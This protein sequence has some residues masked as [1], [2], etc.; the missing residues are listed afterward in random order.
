MFKVSLVDRLLEPG[1]NDIPL[2]I[3]TIGLGLFLREY[4]HEA[5]FATPQPFPSVFGN[6]VWRPGGVAITADDVGVIVVCTAVIAAR[7]SSS[8]AGPTSD[9]RLE[10]AAQNAETARVLGIPVG[11][12]VL[13][14]FAINA[15]LVTIAALLVSRPASTLAGT[16]ALNLGLLAFTAAIIGGFNQVRGAL[17]GGFLVGVL[18]NWSGA[19]VSNLYREAGP[20]LLLILVHPDPTARPLRSSRGAAD[21]SVG[22][23]SALPGVDRTVDTVTVGP[24]N[25]SWSIGRTR[26][27]PVDRGTTVA[28]AWPAP[29]CSA[30][31]VLVVAHPL[32]P[33][34]SS[35]G[36]A[37]AVAAG[38]FGS[39]LVAANL[40]GSRRQTRN[41]DMVKWIFHR[42]L[43]R[44]HVGVPRRAG[45]LDD[46]RPR[47][48]SQI[49]GSVVVG[50]NLTQGFAGQISL[51]Q[52]AFLGIGAYTSVLLDFGEEISLF[53]LTVDLPD[54][55]F[56]ATIPIAVVVSMVFSV[57]I[58]FPAL[59][60]QGPWLA[61]VT[62]AFN[63]LVFL[64]L[65]NEDALTR[66]SRGASGCCARTSRVVRGRSCCRPTTSST[67][68]SPTWC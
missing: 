45:R 59:R 32:R 34:L 13:L 67:W 53:G 20:L 27:P 2:V 8:C 5:W 40:L 38:R 6:D 9:V 68:G 50:M 44:L 62:L 28:R 26:S 52:A 29:W 18:Q 46:D 11:R 66:G 19:Y 61:F 21:M 7:C 41:G 47:D 48:C 43:R 31:G 64:V 56:L 37:V 36:A 3:A 54:L 42:H 25:R 10:A 22:P 30:F 65:N 33:A 51:A 23:A 12:M 60:V 35:G 55:P 63:L 15:V 39:A 1:G 57:L 49:F 14:T 58:G 4:V 24:G 17:Y 16:P